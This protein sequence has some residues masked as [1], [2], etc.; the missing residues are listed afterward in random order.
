MCDNGAQCWYEKSDGLCIG[1]PCESDVLQF[2]HN[3]WHQTCK[4]CN[5]CVEWSFNNNK[6]S[7]D[8]GTNDDLPLYEIC[9]LCDQR[10]TGGKHLFRSVLVTAE[11]DDLTNLRLNYRYCTRCIPYSEIAQELGWPSANVDN[12]NAVRQW[13][14]QSRAMAIDEMN[15][16]SGN[17]NAKA[18]LETLD[19][20]IS[21]ARA[22]YEQRKRREEKLKTRQRVANEKRLCEWVPRFGDNDIDGE[23]K[24]R[25]LKKMK[26]IEMPE[27]KDA[28]D[29]LLF[30]LTCD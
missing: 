23:K 4:I 1:R 20:L 13:I 12:D 27:C 9:S 19:V 2:W 26:T 17:D 24:E 7:D 29:F 18:T 3:E 15:G 21:E 28:A 6:N 22:R 10:M 14:A 25:V 5:M 8:R 11:A 16:R 30:L